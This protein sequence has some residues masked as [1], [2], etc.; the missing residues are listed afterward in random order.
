M[1]E[2]NR[3]AGRMTHLAWDAKEATVGEVA[4]RSGVARLRAALL[5]ARGADLQPPHGRQP[6]PLRRDVLRRVAFIRTSQRVGIP[7][8]EVRDV[9]GAAAGGP[10]A[11][12]GGLGALS[13]WWRKDLDNRIGRLQRLRDHFTDCIGCGCLSIDRCG[14]ANP[15]DDCLARAGAAPPDRGLSTS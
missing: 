6:A 9:L 5:R 4:E 1:V 10:H 14:L 15:G 13:A 12:P 11:D 7:L 8:A 2:V 3:Y